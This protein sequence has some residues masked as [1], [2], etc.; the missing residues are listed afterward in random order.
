MSEVQQASLILA[1]IIVEEC[2]IR[3]KATERTSYTSIPKCYIFTTF[4]ILV[5]HKCLF[6]CVVDLVFNILTSTVSPANH[7]HI[8]GMVW[9]YTHLFPFLN[10]FC[11]FGS[12]QRKTTANLQSLI[13]C[14]RVHFKILILFSKSSSTPN[15]GWVATD[16]VDVKKSISLQ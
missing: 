7:C 1:D 6:S 9:I 2:T 15:P 8:R 11:L 13:Q 14:I 4:S 5:L 3:Q 16:M 10:D 12:T